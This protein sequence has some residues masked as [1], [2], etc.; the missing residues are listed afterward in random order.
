MSYAM[1]VAEREQFLGQVH[2]GVLSVA[3]G[4][5]RGP[6]S[7][8]VWYSYQPGGLLTFVTGRESRKGRALRAVGRASLLVQ[9]EARPYRY[10]SVEGPAVLAEFDLDERLALA[11]RY[12]GPEGGDQYVADNPDPDGELALFR[13]QPQ[14]WLSV[15]YGKDAGS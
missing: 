10:V 13:I 3:A 14:R 6:I 8:P 7:A 1:S 4:D 12:L 11:R 5:G 15:D 9:S 2:V